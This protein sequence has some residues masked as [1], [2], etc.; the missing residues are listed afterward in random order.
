MGYS[1]NCP[2]CGGLVSP[3]CEIG[4]VMKYKGKDF[5]IPTDLE[6]PTC[7]GCGEQFFDEVL[8]IKIDAIC[9]EEYLKNRG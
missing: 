4:R 2:E 8:C 3:H 5:V 6:I 1:N 7:D 9:E